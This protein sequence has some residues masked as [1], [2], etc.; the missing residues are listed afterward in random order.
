VFRR[1]PKESVSFSVGVR[2]NMCVSAPY[3][4]RACA[5]AR[6]RAPIRTRTRGL[7]T[8]AVYEDE[9]AMSSE[10]EW[11]EIRHRFPRIWTKIRAE[12]LG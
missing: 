12:N 7:R 3:P 11:R 1:D 8:G 10:S 5:R 2:G 9:G 4:T 6:A